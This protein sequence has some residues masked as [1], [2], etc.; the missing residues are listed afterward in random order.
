MALFKQSVKNRLR[1][2]RSSHFGNKGDQI[3]LLNLVIK[4]SNMFSQ[5]RIFKLP[6]LKIDEM[7]AKCENAHPGET[8][9]ELQQIESSFT[10]AR[11]VGVRCDPTFTKPVWKEDS[12]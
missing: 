1:K 4:N 5:S 7:K 6:N 10:R 11:G 3:A 8:C 9:V 12:Y 2:L